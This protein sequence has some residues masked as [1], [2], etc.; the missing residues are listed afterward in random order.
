[1]ASKKIADWHN[2]L[3]EPGCLISLF[4][5]FQHHNHFSLLEVNERD[6]SIIHYDS[7]GSENPD[8]KVLFDCF[9]N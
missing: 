4:P 8:I 5:L 2:E 7:M 6:N 3:E 9:G 1:M